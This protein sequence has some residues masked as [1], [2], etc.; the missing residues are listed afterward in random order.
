MTIYL[1]I[2]VETNG[3]SIA[4]RE[5][6]RGYRGKEYEVTRGEKERGLEEEERRREAGEG[7]E[8]EKG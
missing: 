5:K 4:K 8:E 7:G 6:V 3:K 1:L 2:G